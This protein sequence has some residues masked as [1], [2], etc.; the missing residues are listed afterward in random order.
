[1]K[2]LFLLLAAT[3]AAKAAVLAQLGSHPLLQPL[4]DIDS[5]VYARLASRIAGGDILLRGEGAVPYFVSP[6]YVYFLAAT[7]PSFALARA[8]QILL[9]TAAVALVFLT[10]RRLFGER[11]AL[12]AGVLYALTGVVTFHEVLILQAALD[13]FL[14][15]LF[16][17]LLARALRAEEEEKISLKVKRGEARGG[18]S[19]QWVALAAAGAAGGLLCL[20]RPNALLCVAAVAA[21]LFLFT[22]KEDLLRGR[23]PGCGI[24][25]GH[26]PGGCP[27]HSQKSPRLPRACPDLLAR[28]AELPRRQRAGRHGR[29]PR[30][31]RDHAGHRRAGGRHEARRGGRGGAAALDARGLGALREKAWSWIRESPAAAALS[32][33]KKNPIHSFRRRGAA[34]L[35]LPV[36]PREEP[37]AEAPRRR[38]R[39]PRAARGRGLRPRVPRVGGRRRA[40]RSSSGPRSSRRTSS[41]SRRSSSRRGTASRSSSP[42]HRSRGAAVARP[43]GGVA[44]E[45]ARLGL[46]AAAAAVLA[47]VSLWPTGLWDGAQDEEMHLVLWEIERGDAGA[48]RARRGRRAGAPRSGAR[49]AARGPLLRGGGEDGRGD[50]GAFGAP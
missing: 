6:L 26:R 43:A 33:S 50:R 3:L 7:G 36:V 25:R 21:A 49:L 38:A 15:A 31:P 40:G 4:G 5:G 44:G 23:R 14:T 1:M 20:N 35:Q 30:D 9:G 34:Q 29:L 24:R 13:P 17:F 46:A 8:V 10:A 37:R 45:G 12:A 39:P 42:S 41:R 2:R 48:M 22:F 16:L 19:P 32:L 28:R 27:F 18:A 11:A 47:A